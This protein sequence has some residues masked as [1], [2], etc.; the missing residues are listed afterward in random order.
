MKL[1]KKL[2]EGHKTIDERSAYNYYRHRGMETGLQNLMHVP[3]VKPLTLKESD[4][5][6]SVA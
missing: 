2:E 1:C 5:V 3:L 6:V 4:R